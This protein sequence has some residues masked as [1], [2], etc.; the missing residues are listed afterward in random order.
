MKITGIFSGS[1]TLGLFWLAV[2]LGSCTIVQNID[3]SSN[4]FYSVIGSS[5]RNVCTEFKRQPRIG[6][7][8]PKL[9]KVDLSKL[10][11]D[12]INDILITYAERMKQYVIDDEKYLD[13]DILRHRASCQRNSP[14][15]FKMDSM[16]NMG[17]EPH[18]SNKVR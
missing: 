3:T 10:S 5:Q 4:N 1:R 14:E 13:E 9:P 2:S 8:K 6:H 7:A 17:V 12:E 15:F 11:Q 18:H 16:Y